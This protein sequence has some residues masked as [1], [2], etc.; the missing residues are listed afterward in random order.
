MEKLLEVNNLAAHFFTDKGVLP[1]VDGID[2]DVKKGEILAIVGESGCGKSVSSMCIINMMPPPGKIVNGEILFKGE[3]IL[4]KSTEQMRKIRGNEI[5]I[6]F[7]DPMSSLNPVIKIG[8]QLIET[9]ICHL[10]I[11]KAE[12]KHRAIQALGSVGIPDPITFMNKYPHELSGGMC[13]RVMIAIAIS[14]EPDILIADEPTTALDVTIQA[15]ILRLLKNLRDERGTSIILITH[16]MGV[17]AQMAD[18]VLVMYAG[19]A[20]EEGEVNEIFKNPQHPY[21]VGLLE[22]I[23]NPDNGNKQLYNIKGTVPGVGEYPEG[24]RFAPRCEFRTDKCDQE[25]PQYLGEYGHFVR[26]HNRGQ[27]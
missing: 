24:C 9:M 17:V 8:K 13:Q 23:P 20:V 5:S 18:R 19:L 10:N 12:A 22:S 16:D 21:T 26:C 7:Q 14:C 27:A 4:A 2:F 25:L 6:I 15:Q 1:A 11:S 3:N